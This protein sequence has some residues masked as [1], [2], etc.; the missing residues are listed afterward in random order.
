[1]NKRIEHLSLLKGLRSY[2]GL[3]LLHLIVAL[4][5]VFPG[6]A[7]LTGCQHKEERTGAYAPT[8]TNNCLPDIALTDQ[9]GKKVSLSSLKGKPVL[10]DFIYTTCP[11]PC[12]MLTSRM[13]LIANKIGPEV[14]GSK[15]WF[16][17]VTVDPEHDG[18][19]QLLDYSKEQGADENGWLFLTGTPVQIDQVMS[20]F[21]LVR[22]REANGTVDHVL[23]FF[24]VGPDGRQLYQYAASHA[25]ATTIA[26]DIEQ[27]VRTGAVSSRDTS[28]QK[29]HL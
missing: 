14:L 26:G 29:V 27:A 9:N 1:M 6:F 4:A 21:N 10:F 8:T 7:T 18:P 11:G 25:D 13:R 28:D 5:L 12:L 16:V 15:V 20:Q 22:Q 17:S 23:E 19:A 2:P 3:K 24:L